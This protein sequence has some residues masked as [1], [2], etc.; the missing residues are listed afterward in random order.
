M[1]LEFCV[2]IGNDLTKYDYKNGAWPI[3]L[4]NFYYFMFPE[5]KN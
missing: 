4:D 2:Q 3:F 5:A 1:V